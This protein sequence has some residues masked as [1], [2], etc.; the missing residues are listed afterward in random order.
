MDKVIIAVRVTPKEVDHPNVKGN[1][2]DATVS[3]TLSMLTRL[4]TSLLPSTDDREDQKGGQAVGILDLD[5]EDVLSCA[6][7][8]S[9]IQ[10]LLFVVAYPVDDKDILYCADNYEDEL[11][12]NADVS[13]D[14]NEVYLPSVDDPRE[15]DSF[16]SCTFTLILNPDP[17][18]KE[19]VSPY[20]L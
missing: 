17:L 6:D 7:Y 13:C 16:F 10:D 8:S 5:E 18:L 1:Q 3:L 2:M 15:Q 4:Q 14:T 9:D 12:Y 19:R 20:C 11:M